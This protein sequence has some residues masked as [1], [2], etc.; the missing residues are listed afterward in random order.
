MF[1][2]AEFRKPAISAGSV[3]PAYCRNLLLQTSLYIVI[4]KAALPCIARFLKSINKAL[5]RA[6]S[7]ELMVYLI[8]LDGWCYEDDRSFRPSEQ[9]AQQIGKFLAV[10][11]KTIFTVILPRTGDM[12][13]AL[14]NRGFLLERLKNGIRVKQKHFIQ[15]DGRCVCHQWR[16]S[17]AS[18]S[19]HDVGFFH[20]FAWNSSI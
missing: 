10:N 16:G 3:V 18:N 19:G 13:H 17:M 12:Y 1:P 15:S 7:V 5:A 9:P 11:G 2:S 6:A 8:Y 20:W 14:L 4:K